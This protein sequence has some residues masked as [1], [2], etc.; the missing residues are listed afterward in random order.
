MSNQIDFN[1][2]RWKRSD[3][4]LWIFLSNWEE[5]E[6]D[7]D[8]FK[9]TTNYVTDLISDKS[10]RVPELNDGDEQFVTFLIQQLK[11]SFPEIKETP[12]ANKL[13]WIR[14]AFSALKNGIPP[15]ARFLNEYARWRYKCSIEHSEINVVRLKDSSNNTLNQKTKKIK[16]KIYES[17]SLDYFFLATSLPADLDSL[18]IWRIYPSLKQRKPSANLSRPF[19]DSVGSIAYQYTKKC[20]IDAA[21]NGII[22]GL[23]KNKLSG[24]YKST[25]SRNELALA[26]KKKYPKEII[27]SVQVIKKIITKIVTCPPYRRIRT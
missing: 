6:I 9:A 19:E 2:D 15:S 13:L 23:L 18:S 11:K 3:A 4:L 20:I 8:F 25:I 22:N 10:P 14:F 1:A 27:N 16:D 24:R 21:N 5:L 17:Y 7:A 12:E 26:L